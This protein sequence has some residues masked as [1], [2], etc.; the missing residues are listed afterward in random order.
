MN[1]KRLGSLS[2][3]HWGLLLAM[4]VLTIAYANFADSPSLMAAVTTRELPVYNVDT[5]EKVLSV[6][7]DAAWGRANTEG[8]LDILDQYGVKANFF[9]VGFWAEKSIPN[10]SPNC[11]PGNTRCGIISATYPH[12][13]KLSDAQIREGAETM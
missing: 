3:R 6:S 12:M 11:R 5:E 7:F 8:I 13:S 2:M 4:A 9:L 1:K 10:W